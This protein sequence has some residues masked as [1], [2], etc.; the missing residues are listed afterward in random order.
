MRGP[1]ASLLSYP[2]SMTD[3]I[4]ELLI[5]MAVFD[6]DLFRYVWAKAS[7]GHSSRL[8]VVGRSSIVVYEVYGANGGV[9][10]IQLRLK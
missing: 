3:R 2:C 6:R 1:Q 4:F 9:D 10:I 7:N 5:S 8:Y